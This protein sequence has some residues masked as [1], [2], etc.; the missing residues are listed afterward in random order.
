M[1]TKDKEVYVEFL[2]V[3]FLVGYCLCSV[4][5]DF[6]AVFVADLDDF[7]YREGVAV[8]VAGPDDADKFCVF[9]FLLFLFL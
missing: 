5:E 6:C 2:H 4:E 3:C 7:F 1:S 9:Y 8:K